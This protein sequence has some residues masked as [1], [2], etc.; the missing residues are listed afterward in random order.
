MSNAK[1]SV[2]Q[3]NR[4]SD[5]GFWLSFVPVFGGLS[6]IRESSRLSNTKGVQLGW[7][8]FALSVVT[9]MGGSFG[10]AWML[11]I[12]LAIWLRFQQPTRPAP[13]ALAQVDF[14]SCYKHELVRVLNLPIVYANDIDLIRIEVHLFI[15][16]EELTEIA[17]V[18]EEL[19]ARITPQLI[20]SYDAAKDD[21]HTWRQINFL[22]ASEMVSR[23]VDAIAAEKIVE[24]RTLRGDYRS[25]VEV[26]RRTGIAF[27]SYQ[28]LV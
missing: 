2:S 19:V 13:S 21:D 24:E 22:T 14:N 11:Q 18:P 25:A 8:V 17:G 16:A 9:A 28:T 20:F 3:S 1:L 23:G 7:C 4:I 10:F 26:K 12:G 6:I 27:R 5:N 15:H